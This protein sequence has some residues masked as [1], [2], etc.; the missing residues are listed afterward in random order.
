MY[1][2]EESREE[3]IEQHTKEHFGQKGQQQTKHECQEVFGEEVVSKKVAGEKV[4]REKVLTPEIFSIRRQERRNRNEG[5]EA[6]QAQI[7]AQRQKGNESQAGDRH[8]ALESEERGQEGSGQ[9]VLSE[10]EDNQGPPR[11]TPPGSSP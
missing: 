5:D 1:G 6:G 3:E 7:R 4:V 2:N 8:R 10:T 9:K 11:F